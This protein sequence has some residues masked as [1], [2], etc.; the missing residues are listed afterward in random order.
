MVRTIREIE[1]ENEGNCEFVLK[2]FFIFPLSLSVSPLPAQSMFQGRSSLWYFTLEIAF[3]SSWPPPLSGVTGCDIDIMK[4]HPLSRCQHIFFELLSLSLSFCNS[5]T[6]AQN[7]GQPTVM[8][9]LL[10]NLFKEITELLMKIWKKELLSCGI[11][12]V[13]CFSFF[14]FKKWQ[15]SVCEKWHS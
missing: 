9:V 3:P 5:W 15:Q 2:E 13:F 11:H 10:G 8:F 6:L 4:D 14:F 1:R 7:S 12:H